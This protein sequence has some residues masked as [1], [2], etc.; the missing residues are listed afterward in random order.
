GRYVAGS[1][2]TA[3]CGLG[4]FPLPCHQTFPLLHSVQT[5]TLP[6]MEL[7][8]SLT[9][10]HS[11][12]AAVLLLVTI[13]SRAEGN[14]KGDLVN[15]MNYKPDAPTVPSPSNLIVK[16]YNFNTTLCW[17]FKDTSA[18]PRF[19]VE[20]KVF[21]NWSVVETCQNISQHY[22]DLSEEIYDPNKFYKIKIKA[23][24]GPEESESTMEDDFSIRIHG[25]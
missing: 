10:G 20:F 8:R 7:G 13:V 22:C 9:H 18:D 1:V 4:E 3:V 23:F 15:V 19:Q 11:Y 24:V 2:P 5:V 12:L 17:D 6:T 16:S 21:G 14:Q 25:K